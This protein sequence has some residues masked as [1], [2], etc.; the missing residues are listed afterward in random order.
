MSILLRHQLQCSRNCKGFLERYQKISTLQGSKMQYSCERSISQQLSR[1]L[2]LCDPSQS[3]QY[4]LSR[5]YS[6]FYLCN[7]PELFFPELLAVQAPFWGLLFPLALQE[8][9]LLLS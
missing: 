3:P 2:K 1:T 8:I 5:L 9:Q 7:T 4:E 6:A